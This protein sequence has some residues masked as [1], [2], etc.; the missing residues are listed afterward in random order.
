[1]FLRF[2]LSQCS[3]LRICSKLLLKV[4]NSISCSSNSVHLCDPHKLLCSMLSTQAGH[5]FSL[6][7]CQGQASQ[8][9]N[10]TGR[11]RTCCPDGT[12]RFISGCCW[13]RCRTLSRYHDPLPEFK[14][15][16]DHTQSHQ[17]HEQVSL[18]TC[19]DKQSRSHVLCLKTSHIYRNVCSSIIVFFM[20]IC[21]Y[22]HV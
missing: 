16:L 13:G 21:I 14:Q 4:S 2:G 7:N 10:R 9:T 1:M 22:I 20:S 18:C 8:V 5:Q 19:K 11:C 12:R 6:C 15:Q 17:Q 3:A